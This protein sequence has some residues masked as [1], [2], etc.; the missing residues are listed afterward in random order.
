M[1]FFSTSSPEE[2]MGSLE[3][4]EAQISE[5][6]S[7]LSVSTIGELIWVQ[8]A[9]ERN[10]HEKSLDPANKEVNIYEKKK[11]QISKLLND[12]QSM[13]SK[14]ANLKNEKVSVEK[15]MENLKTN[16][17]VISSEKEEIKVERDLLA[18]EL[19]RIGRLYEGLTGKEASQEDLKSVL[20]IYITLMEDVFSGRA[21]FKVLSIIHGEKETWKRDE[22]AKSSGI[23]EIQLRSVLGDL[24]R[25][26]MIEYDEET[27]NVKLKK[28][29]SALE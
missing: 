10:F 20:N 26:N 22:L 15:E 11:E 27:T 6:I 24:V 2:T 28:R 19:Q 3:E 16:L 12:Y 18:E 23:A 9:L 25:A 5:I 13:I 4:R 8:R 29:I 21:H 14:V 1:S 17:S 7:Y